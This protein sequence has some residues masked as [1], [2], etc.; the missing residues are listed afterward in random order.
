MPTHVVTRGLPSAREAKESQR[1]V[2][3]GRY[4]VSHNPLDQQQNSRFL[5]RVHGPLGEDG[6]RDILDDFATYREAVND[7]KARERADVDARRSAYSRLCSEAPV[8]LAT[9]D[10]AIA[11]LLADYHGTAPFD[12]ESQNA[13]LWELIYVASRARGLPVPKEIPDEWTE[14]AKWAS[15]KPK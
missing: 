1:Y 15:R 14:A 3:I 5:W 13:L 11:E 7:A 12:C 9:L 10:H 4:A 8:L 6:T 2:E